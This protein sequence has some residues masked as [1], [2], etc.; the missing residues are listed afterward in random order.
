MRSKAPVIRLIMLAAALTMLVASAASGSARQPASRSADAALGSS[1][2]LA[3][4]GTVLR[5]Q[6]SRPQPA[7]G[8]PPWR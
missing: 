4:A 6:S 7:A 5:H 1:R 2:V 3:G 8:S